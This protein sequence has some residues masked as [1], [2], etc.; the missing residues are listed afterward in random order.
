MHDTPW[1]SDVFLRD[2]RLVVADVALE[3]GRPGPLGTLS[4]S[5]S[6]RDGAPT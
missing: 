5:L 2:G 6:E 4:A 3:G 1:P